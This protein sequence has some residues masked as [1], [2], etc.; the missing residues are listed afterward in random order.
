MSPARLE[1]RRATE[2]RGVSAGESKDSSGAIDRLQRHLEKEIVAAAI[3]LNALMVAY[4]QNWPLPR[5]FLAEHL[6]LT[7]LLVPP[8]DEK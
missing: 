2:G 6:R 8:K 3:E 5:A 1:L 4:H 7:A